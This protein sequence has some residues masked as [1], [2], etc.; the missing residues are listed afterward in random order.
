MRRPADHGVGRRW[1]RRQTA[2]HPPHRERHP[3][4]SWRRL[5]EDEQLLPE[6]EKFEIAI[7]GGAG[8]KDE[9]VDDQ[10]EERIGESQQHGQAE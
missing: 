8:A 1:G 2:A 10:P 9:E 7:G 6:D 3:A 5:A 4:R